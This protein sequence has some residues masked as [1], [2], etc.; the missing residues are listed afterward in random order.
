MRI[1]FRVLILSSLAISHFCYHKLPLLVCS[2]ADII[3]SKMLSVLLNQTF[4][5]GLKKSSGIPAD[6]PWCW[7]SLCA[8]GLRSIL[9]GKPLA[10]FS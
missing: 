10:S 7:V 1:S 8:V 2:N 3:A 4:P 9:L 5:V 6:D